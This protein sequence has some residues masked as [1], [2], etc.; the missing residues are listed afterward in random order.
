MMNWN[1][2][3]GFI[4]TGDPIP[5][6][7]EGMEVV[8]VV[9]LTFV[10]GYPRN[11]LSVGDLHRDPSRGGDIIVQLV[12]NPGNKYDSNAI[13]VRLDN[14][15][16]GHLPKEVAARIAPKI[17]SGEVKYLA[18]IYQVRISPDNPNQPGLDVLLDGGNY[19]S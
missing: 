2:I 14:R 18:T 7:P 3:R 8:P 5:Q 11:I 19:D 13:E 6:V 9:G 15:M 12:R 16:L 10:E 17:D 4:E 1:S